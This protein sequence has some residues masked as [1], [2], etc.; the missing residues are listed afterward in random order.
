M[1]E[2][3]YPVYIE[4]AEGSRFWDVDGN[5]Y[6]DYLMGF[7]PIVLG[8]AHPAVTEAVE[9]QIRDGIVYSVGHPLEIELAERILAKIPWAARLAF[10]I[11]GSGATSAAIRLAR[12]VTG[13]D[14]VLRCGYHGWHD[15][16][17][18]NE[19]GIPPTAR[20]LSLEFPY[21]D[22][23]AL[24]ELLKKHRGRAAAV[25]VETLRFAGPDEGFLQGCIDLAHEYGALCI[26]DE[27]K[28]G[29]RVEIGGVSVREGLTPDLAT[30][31]KAW[32]NGLPASFVAGSEEVMTTEAAQHAWVAAT[33]HADALS[34]VAIRTVLDELEANDGIQHQWRLGQRMID[35]VNAACEEAGISYR[36][37]GWPPMPNPKVEEEDK[38]RVLTILRGCL[39]RGVYLH[40]GHAMFLSLAHT[41]EDVDQTIAAVRESIGEMEPGT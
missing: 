30:Y 16:T 13:R 15:W 31:G 37:T 20:A 38:E 36:L 18:P 39:R 40:P 29:C 24:G 19:S 6:V 2:R 11:G 32:G 34:M 33:F 27:V 7:G 9:R 14:L 28:T 3:G 23:E 12:A 21:N 17:S 8:H 4:R 22:L 10:M 41:E 35:G 5:E 1:L 25:M 26:F